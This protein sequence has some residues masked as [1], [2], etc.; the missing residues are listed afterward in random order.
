MM[1]V[2]GVKSINSSSNQNATQVVLH[3]DLD[4]DINEIAREVQAA[5][6]AAYIGRVRALARKVARSYYN[7]RE[8]LGFPM[9]KTRP[10]TATASAE[11]K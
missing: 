3:F 10:A 5:I 4:T 11:A 6:N 9:C 8:A 1:G 2:S 7:S